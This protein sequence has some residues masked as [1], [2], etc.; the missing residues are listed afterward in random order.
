GQ[1]PLGP[2]G[3]QQVQQNQQAAGAA[4]F[5]FGL[6][7]ALAMSGALT[8]GQQQNPL[9]QGLGVAAL[10]GAGGNNNFAMGGAFAFG[11]GIQNFLGA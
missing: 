4:A 9:Q 2:L 7:L 6:G 3:N 10:A 11:G 1:S 5:G 8:G